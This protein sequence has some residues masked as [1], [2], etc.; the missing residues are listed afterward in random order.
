MSAGDDGLTVYLKTP[1]VRTA[2]PI[3]S[4]MIE[5]NRAA[6]SED[7]GEH[8]IDDFLSKPNL[9]AIPPLRLEGGVTI[10]QVMLRCAVC[11][12]PCTALAG[13]RS[14]PFSWLAEF[15][16][17]GYCE[18]CRFFTPFDCRL[19][20]KSGESGVMVLWREYGEWQ[21]A[22]AVQETW[23]TPRWWGIAIR[24]ALNRARNRLRL[25]PPSA[26]GRGGDDQQR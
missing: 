11:E 10:K 9:N 26:Q 18:E 24:R 6:T 8:L 13:E 2:P 20:Q 3:D 17:L 19:R 12:L 4:R 15:F 14:Q 22:L 7:L 25:P 23:S 1:R 16:G 5:S 21:N